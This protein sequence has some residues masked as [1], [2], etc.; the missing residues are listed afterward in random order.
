MLLRRVRIVNLRVG[1]LI[2][3]GYRLVEYP[4]GSRALSTILGISLAEDVTVHRCGHE[5]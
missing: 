2:S 5:W 3:T 1:T 4:A